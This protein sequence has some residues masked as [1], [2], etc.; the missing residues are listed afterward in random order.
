M[1]DLKRYIVTVEEHTFGEAKFLGMKFAQTG[2]RVL[3]TVEGERSPILSAIVAM[4]EDK[5]HPA[6]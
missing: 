5:P 1:S 2:K 3:L 4:V 6:P